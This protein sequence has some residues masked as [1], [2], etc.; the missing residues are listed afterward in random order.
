MCGSSAINGERR[1]AR[2]RAHSSGRAQ[3]DA[4]ARRRH[5][6]SETKPTHAQERRVLVAA[7]AQQRYVRIPA[8]VGVD[9][10]ELLPWILLCMFDA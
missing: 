2:P 6:R 10:Y 7:D 8:A 5:R 3:A 4:T 1:R 9:M